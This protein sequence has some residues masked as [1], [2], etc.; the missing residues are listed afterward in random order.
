[1]PIDNTAVLRQIDEILARFRE[2]EGRAKFD[3][4]N[5]IHYGVSNT[6]AT[7]VI[8]LVK[9]TLERFRPP[10]SFTFGDEA[11]TKTVCTVLPEPVGCSTRTSPVAWQTLKTSFSW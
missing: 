5:Q 10:G 4:H 2:V 8:T 11:L 6:E 3:E 7:E 1:M 9:H